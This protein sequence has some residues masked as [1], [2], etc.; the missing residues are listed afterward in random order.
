MSNVADP[1]HPLSLQGSIRPSSSNT[2][3]MKTEVLRA[4]LS[5]TAQT[6]SLIC[7]HSDC[8]EMEKSVKLL[9]VLGLVRISHSCLDSPEAYKFT[10]A[11]CRLTY[12]AAVVLNEKTTKVIE[13]AFQH[14]KYPSIEGVKSMSFM[15][16]VQ[17]GFHNLEI[18][19]LSIGKSEF[20]LKEN[21]GIRLSISNVSAVFK[22]TINYGYGSWLLSLRQS[23]DFEIESH[24]DLGINPKLYCG[25]GKV[26]ADTSDCYL[27]FHKLKLLLQGDREPGWLKKIFTDIVTFTVKLVVK[28]QICKEI[29][30]VANILADF[31]QEQ[32]EQFL[33]DG[34]IGVDIS[35]TSHP[36]IKSNYIESYHKGLVTYKNE[37]SFFNTSV[38][39][40]SQLS[41]NRMIY[42]WFSDRLLD[43]LMGA[44][45]LDGRFVRN[46]SG[47]EL[48]DL[49]QT[50][51]SSARPEL[52]NK[53]L[54]S[55]GPMLKAKSVSVPHMWTTTQGTFVRAVAGVE[56]SL[57]HQHKPTLYFETNVTVV[58]R[59]SYA[60]KKLI[61]KATAEL[62]TI[63]EVSTSGPIVMN[64]S[65]KTYLQ[66]AVEK[67]G[68]PKVLSYLEAELLAL[69][70]EQGLNL[71]DIINPEVIPQD[72]YVM[73]QLDFGFPHHLLVEFLKRTLD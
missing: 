13:A 31:I 22:G 41:E 50:E 11:V 56:I 5:V 71:F 24:I 60:E 9:L 37:T 69:M 32:A 40:P 43:P 61:L 48:T 45:H 26:A 68:I 1:D 67:M 23:V 18:H 59:A 8:V 10:G 6:Q 70:D 55:E 47:T 29:N 28:S 19:N 64:E 57:A 65:L 42:F 25:K 17:Y 44:V 39:N 35:V 58:V 49:F 20:E 27:T 2:G 46:I 53:W 14:A 54:S 63:T 72:E 36:I 7:I 73:V 33:S 16:E 30:N 52:L 38:F 15:G 62:I 4:F 12:P 51:I 3:S 21:E 66:E 34:N